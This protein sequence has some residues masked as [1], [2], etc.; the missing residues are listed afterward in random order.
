MKKVVFTLLILFTI[1]VFAQN[2]AKPA[3]ANKLLGF[4]TGFNYSN[5]QASTTL[6]ENAVLYNSPG[7]RLG[8]MLDYSIN[9]HLGFSPKAELAFSNSK[10]RMTNPDNSVNDYGI[11]RESLELMTH[12]VVKKG[13]GR[14]KPYLLLGPNIRLPLYE[15][16]KFVGFDSN[17]DLAADIGF[18]FEKHFP[19]LF[20]APEIRYSA[21]LFNVNKYPAVPSA[22]YFHNIVF[23]L[24]FR[25]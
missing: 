12:I 21:G 23:A 24:N 10:I 13:S 2:P 6:P 25:G 9:E 14:L 4:T 1:P 16:P 18:G 17:P 15:R 11:F 5:I 8:I 22:L 20:V 7:F 3:P 19:K